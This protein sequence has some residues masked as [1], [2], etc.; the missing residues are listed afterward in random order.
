[1][2]WQ[3]M[4]ESGRLI[5][6]HCRAMDEADATESVNLLFCRQPSRPHP[7]AARA[8]SRITQRIPQQV[9]I[10][11]LMDIRRGY[12]RITPSMQHVARPFFS[13]LRDHSPRPAG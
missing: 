2:T 5:N 12:K 7:L 1:M 10:H 8:L 9:G 13:R 3:E 4:R 11:R 6:V